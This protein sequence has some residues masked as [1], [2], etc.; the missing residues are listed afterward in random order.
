MIR[1]KLTL[2]AIRTAPRRTRLLRGDPEGGSDGE[3][4]GDPDGDPEG[5]EDALAIRFVHAR[6]AN[7]E[8]YLYLD[9]AKMSAPL[10]FDG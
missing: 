7:N 4:E 2:T 1:Q 3:S 5:A 6:N 9:G 8:S 10:Y